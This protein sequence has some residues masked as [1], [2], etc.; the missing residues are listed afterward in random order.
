MPYLNRLAL[1]F[2]KSTRGKPWCVPDYSPYYSIVH[3]WKWPP[4]LI[5]RSILHLVAGG[6]KWIATFIY[7]SVRVHEAR[8]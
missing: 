2:L 5:H 1:A 3:P 6:A 4:L 7:F 8:N